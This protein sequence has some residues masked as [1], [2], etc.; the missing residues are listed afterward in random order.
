M[1]ASHPAGSLHQG[2][3]FGATR[4]IVHESEDE[5]TVIGLQGHKRSV[6]GSATQH[7]V[8]R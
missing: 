3:I 7:R 4:L 1:P 2:L 5:M 6:L 8:V